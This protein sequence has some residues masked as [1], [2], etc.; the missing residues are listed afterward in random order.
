M[1]TKAKG[2]LSGSLF[3]IPTKLS[4]VN[5]CTITSKTLFVILCGYFFAVFAVYPERCRRVTAKTAKCFAKNSK[6]TQRAST[7]NYIIKA[8]L[9]EAF[10]IYSTK[11]SDLIS[12]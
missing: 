2:F 12:F 11:L 6:R 10:I 1:R 8:S 3:Y 9:Q 5:V 7:S 4:S